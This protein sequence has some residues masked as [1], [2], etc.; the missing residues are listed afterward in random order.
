LPRAIPGT[1]WLGDLLHGSGGG[2][3]LSRRSPRRPAHHCAP[4]RERRAGCRPGTFWMAATTSGA[5]ALVRDALGVDVDEAFALAP[6]VDPLARLTRL[7]PL[8]RLGA[9]EGGEMAGGVALD[10]EHDARRDAPQCRARSAA[11]DRVKKERH[12]VVDDLEHRHVCSRGWLRLRPAT[13]SGC[14]TCGLA[15]ARC[16]QASAQARPPR[17]RHSA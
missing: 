16:A 7:V 1:G 4:V 8:A 17:A 12:V 6:F 13:H 14:W 10:R 9:L 2:L 5:L 15:V 3:L 11:H